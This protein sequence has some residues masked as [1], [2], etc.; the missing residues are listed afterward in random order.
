[1]RSYKSNDKWEAGLQIDIFSK[2]FKDMQ[3]GDNAITQFIEKN[4]NINIFVITKDH[5]LGVD[6]NTFENSS[7]MNFAGLYTS[8]R[9]FGVLHKLGFKEQL[10]N[11]NVFDESLKEYNS[12]DWSQG[13]IPSDEFENYLERHLQLKRI[14]DKVTTRRSKYR[15]P[16]QEVFRRF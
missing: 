12:Q 11:G 7:A 13:V 15:S 10:P 5:R 6:V 16:E 14:K 4:P 3:F 9:D 8:L 1:M 2:H